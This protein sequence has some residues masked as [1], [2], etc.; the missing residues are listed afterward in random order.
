MFKNLEI[1]NLSIG[2][3]LVNLGEVLEISENEDCFSLVIA[4]R[5]QRQVWTFGKEE[6]V[7]IV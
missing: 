1:A 2:D 5:G 3:T 7:F 4:R 6:E